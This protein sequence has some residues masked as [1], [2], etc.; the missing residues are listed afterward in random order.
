MDLD[1]IQKFGYTTSGISLY[2]YAIGLMSGDQLMIGWLGNQTDKN[3]TEV[4][5]KI[6]KIRS[7]ND[8]PVVHSTFKIQGKWKEVVLSLELTRW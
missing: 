7:L 1:T 6:S 4:T 8:C 5:D 2:S 3:I